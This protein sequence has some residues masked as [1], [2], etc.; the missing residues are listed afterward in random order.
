MPVWLSVPDE[1]EGVMNVSK[2][3]GLVATSLGGGNLKTVASGPDSPPQ[4]VG[5]PVILLI[6]QG[7][8]PL[9]PSFI[10]GCKKRKGGIDNTQPVQPQVAARHMDEK[11]RYEQIMALA[12]QFKKQA[13]QNIR[14]EKRRAGRN[15]AP[16]IGRWQLTDESFVAMASHTVSTYCKLKPVEAAALVPTAA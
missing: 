5:N 9:I 10:E 15:G 7:L 13:Q 12:V 6:L 2:F 16:D 3:C 4:V 11:S 1:K 8:L 14:D